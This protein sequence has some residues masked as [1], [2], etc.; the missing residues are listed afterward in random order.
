MH[1]SVQS[2]PISSSLHPPLIPSHL[3]PSLPPAIP[4]SPS[5][6]LPPSPPPPPPSLTIRRSEWVVVRSQVNEPVPLASLT[7]MSHG[8]VRQAKDGRQAGA[9]AAHHRPSPFHYH[10]VQPVPQRVT[11]I[12]G[13]SQRCLLFIVVREEEVVVRGMEEREQKAT[14]EPGLALLDCREGIITGKLVSKRERSNKTDPPITAVGCAGH[15]STCNCRP[16]T[17]RESQ[18]RLA[19][20][21][22]DLLLAPPSVEAAA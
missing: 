21:E 2:Y 16:P 20:D 19:A 5:P 3:H 17:H 13:G 6:S 1:S 9:P 11:S 12:Y 7:A 4:R 10:D 8:G 18:R 14:R 22:I 15:R